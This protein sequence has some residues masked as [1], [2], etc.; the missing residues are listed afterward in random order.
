MDKKQEDQAKQIQTLSMLVSRM[1]FAARLGMQY[2]TDRDLYEALGYPLSMDY[3]DYYAKYTRQDMAKAIIDRPVKVTWQ[4][5]VEILESD[6]DKETAL[7]KAWK[8][9]NKELGLLS[10]FIRL[11]KLAGIGKYGV[12]LLGLDDT[13]NKEG[14]LQ[15]VSSGKRTLL[16]IKP[17]GEGNAQIANWETKTSNPRYGMPLTYDISTTNPGG[18]MDSIVRVH[19]SRVIHVTG[20]TLESEIEGAP[21]LEVVYNRLMDLEKVVG[22]DAEMFWRGARPGFQGKVDKDFQLT[23]PMKEDLQNQIDEY[24]HNLRR[25]LVNEG[26][27]YEALAQQIADPKP[28]VDVY[29]QMISAVTTIPKRILT[30]SERGELS[31]AQDRDEWNSYVQSRRDD[32]AETQIVRPFVDRC[33]EYKVLPKPTDEYSV[34]WEDLFSI[35]EKDKVEIGKSRA[36]ALKE[37]TQNPMAEFIIPPDIFYRHFLGFTEEQVELIEE[38]KKAMEREEPEVTEQETEVIEQETKE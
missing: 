32:Y 33:I 29:I 9:L 1:Q 31:S 14:F 15:P 4:G 2:G 3:K 10:R 20:E 17:F 18:G 38:R 8:D 19:Y 35:S 16:Y 25:I 30:G 26:V 11:D 28:H 5:G 7:E 22:G 27:S 6:D 12:L 36:L 21:R 34:Q 23:T 24:E 37:Y 13:Q